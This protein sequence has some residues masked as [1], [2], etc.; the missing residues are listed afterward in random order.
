[1]VEGVWLGSYRRG[2][3]PLA[4]LFVWVWGPLIQTQLPSITAS[5]MAFLLFALLP[6]FFATPPVLTA[7][8]LHPLPSCQSAQRLSVQ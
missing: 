2:L 3:S 5:M 4:S 1:M 7:T 8:L 6:R